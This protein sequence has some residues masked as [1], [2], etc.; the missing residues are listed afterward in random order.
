MTLSPKERYDP[1]NKTFTTSTGFILKIKPIGPGMLDR[2]Q[3]QF[4][5]M[6]KYPKPPKREVDYGKN[7]KE[8]IDDVNNPTYTAAV[9][10]LDEQAAT[11]LVEWILG[12]GSDF[13][14]PDMSQNEMIQDYIEGENTK[15]GSYP[16]FLQRYLVLNTEIDAS[17]YNFLMEVIVG[18]KG[19]TALGLEQAA[20]DF[21]DSSE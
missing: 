20:E 19:V 1:N 3:K 7:R 12:M 13:T 21:P 2:K 4:Q 10:E 5:K 18:S 16:P 9:A 8:W 15:F 17:D 14:I 6:L 11:K